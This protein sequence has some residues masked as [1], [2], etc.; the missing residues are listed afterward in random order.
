MPRKEPIKLN[1]FL[2]LV[3]EEQ[4]VMLI[5]SDLSVVG[6]Q[7]SISCFANSEVNNSRVVNTEAVDSVLKVWVEYDE[8]A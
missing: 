2:S 3:P 5:F 4:N 7:D 6:T 8:T 1:E